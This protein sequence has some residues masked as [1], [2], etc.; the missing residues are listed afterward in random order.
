MM[1]SVGGLDLANRDK[2]LDLASQAAI[3]RDL[4][5]WRSTDADPNEKT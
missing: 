4:E 1:M 3:V 2:S 5:R